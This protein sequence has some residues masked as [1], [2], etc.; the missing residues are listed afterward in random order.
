M[1]CP[2]PARRCVPLPAFVPSFRATTRRTCFGQV[3]A[4]ARCARASSLLARR[5]R[6][7]LARLSFARGLLAWTVGVV[8]RRVGVRSDLAADPTPPPST[9]RCR[10]QFATKSIVAEG[11]TIKAQIWDTAG[12]ERCDPTQPPRFVRRLFPAD[13]LSGGRVRRARPRRRASVSVLSL[14]DAL[15]PSPLF[16]R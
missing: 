3:Q 11:K 8:R 6:A 10:R 15:S 1:P 16:R 9:P 2:T 14:S 12:Q 5:S 13:A 7:P 4:P